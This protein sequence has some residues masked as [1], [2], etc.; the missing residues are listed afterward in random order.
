MPITME[1]I[2]E[3]ACGY[4]SEGQ[5]KS[6]TVIAA[7]NYLMNDE[8]APPEVIAEFSSLEPEVSM[9]IS[10]EITWISLKFA[11]EKS[12]DLSLYFRTLERF[13]EEVEKGHMNKNSLA[14]LS[15][16][17]IEFAGQYYI[18]AMHPIMWAVEPESIG[19]DFRIL[20]IAFFSENIAFLES[21]LEDGFFD[22]ALRAAKE[23]NE[24][25]FSY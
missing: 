3:A 12:S 14:F 6:I 22:E 24:D 13:L 23:A 7:H 8:N 1:E 21:N 2:K 15:V 5:S 11:S 4:D 9:A 10:N 18:N 16:I 20:R 25:Y 19:A 17:P